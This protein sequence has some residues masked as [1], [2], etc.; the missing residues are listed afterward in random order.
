MAYI[1]IIEPEEATG[2]LRDIYDHL[3]KS[4]GKLAEVHKI[5]SLNPGSIMNHMNL[6]MTIMYG[7]S[8]LKRSQREMIAVV[9]SVANQCRYC[10]AHHGE[11]LSHFWKDSER[12]ERLSEDYTQAGLS[13]ADLL[14]CRYAD[15]LSRKPNDSG[16]K[17][18]TAFMKEAG[19]DDRMI[20]DCALITAYFNFVNRLVLGLGVDLE[21]D[22]GKGYL[23]GDQG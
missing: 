23:Y 11:A 19:L 3:I 1:K 18:L 20:L 10:Q 14:L 22:G 7:Q 13:D 12:I 4:R 8:P 6:Y 21:K 5:Q 16:I 17:D 2:E 15:T 9:V